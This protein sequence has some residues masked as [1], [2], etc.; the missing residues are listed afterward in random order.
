MTSADASNKSGVL[1]NKAYARRLFY[2]DGDRDRLRDDLVE[3]LKRT[4]GNDQSWMP[5]CCMDPFTCITIPNRGYSRD[6]RIEICR[7]LKE[8]WSI[9]AEVPDSF[10]SIPVANNMN[11]AFAWESHLPDDDPDG[12]IEAGYRETVDRLW[13]CFRVFVDY[14]RGKRSR[15]EFIEAY[16]RVRA[17]KGVGTPKLTMCLYWIDG[18]FYLSLDG[19]NIALL[20]KQGLQLNQKVYEIDGARYLEF[21]DEFKDHLGKDGRS[22]FD[23]SAEA[24]GSRKDEDDGQWWPSMEEFGTQISKDQWLSL[25]HDPSVFYE[26]SLRVVKQISMMGGDA[27]YKELADKFGNNMDSY[28]TVV[29]ALCKRVQRATGCEIPDEQ[30]AKYWP[31]MFLG[32]RTRG[33]YAYKLREELVEAMEESQDVLEGVEVYSG[34]RPSP[35]EPSPAPK[36]HPLNTIFYGPPGTGKTFVAKRRAVEIVSGRDDIGEGEYAR[37]YERYCSEGRIRMVTFHQSYSYEDFV[38]G[39]CPSLSGGALSYRLRVG[40]FLGFCYPGL[41][42]QVDASGGSP[43]ST[44][45]IEEGRPQ[46]R[47]AFIIDEINR[48]NVSS[49]FGEL[50]TLLEGSKRLGGPDQSRA[51]VPSLGSEVGVPGE[52]YVLG[53]MNTADRSLVYLDA[54]LRRR[55]RFVEMQPRADLVGD[56]G[57]VRLGEVLS[58]INRRIELLLDRDHAMGHSEFM[59]ARTLEDVRELFSRSVIPLLQDY[60]FDDYGRIVSVLSR[61][62]RPAVSDFVRS[63]ADGSFGEERR[64]FRLTPPESWTAEVFNGIVGEG[65]G[66]RPGSG[67]RVGAHSYRPREGGLAAL[68]VRRVLPSGRHGRGAL[69]PG[70]PLR[71]RGGLRRRDR[72]GGAAEGWPLPG[73]VQGA[74]GGDGPHRLL[75]AQEPGQVAVREGQRLRPGVLRV[76]VLPGGRGC[77]R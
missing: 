32:K 59:A 77:D 38:C 61:K 53:T 26:S 54:A 33:V 49:I 6:K 40:S 50:M 21:L 51:S 35:V 23:F 9:E 67:R 11:S 68:E 17:V 70:Y 58:E 34:G 55:F 19:P 10:A 3:M 76:D 12:S 14:P 5:Y 24:Y 57:G 46:G 36:D 64:L 39:I 28:K 60:F 71:G 22:I 18:D 37:L 31:I 45:A 66:Q 7:K 8:Y 62:G 30:G 2:F 42:S 48:G 74:P 69:R 73:R 72:P 13:E 63:E 20:K 1:F 25:L 65:D 29:L 4:N 52:V 16:D 44:E 27:S 47:R 56:V 43:L 15:A 41:Q 75:E